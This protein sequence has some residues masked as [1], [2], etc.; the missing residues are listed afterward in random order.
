M[1]SSDLDARADFIA[2]NLLEDANAQRRMLCRD[3]LRDGVSFRMAGMSADQVTS[4]ALNTLTNPGTAWSDTTNADPV[5]DVMGWISE[6][7]DNNDYGFPPDTG[8]ISEDLYRTYIWPNANVNAYVDDGSAL[9]S[10]HIGALGPMLSLGDVMGEMPRWLGIR[11][12]VFHGTYN[13][14]TDTAQDKWPL[15]QITF[16][17]LQGGGQSVEAEWQ[18]PHDPL[19]TQNTGNWRFELEELDAHG[20][21]G[22][23]GHFYDNGCPMFIEPQLIQRVAD[24][25]P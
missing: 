5:S 14:L 8:F 16:A 13:D 18:M 20:V 19:Y 24:L 9:A 2:R 22:F 11:W 25:T 15:D 1:C 6:F 7:A 10:A 21:K 12:I 4:F 3:A 23:K 17:K